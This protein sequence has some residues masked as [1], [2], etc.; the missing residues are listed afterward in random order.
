MTQIL[1]VDDDR[2]VARLV[3]RCFEGSDVEVLTSQRA[4]EVIPLIEKHTIDVLLLDI[5]LPEISGLDLARQIRKIDSK[6][7]IIFVTGR[8]DSE[9]TI[10]A[11]KLGAYDYLVK[12]LDVGM[13]QELVERAIENRRLMHEPVVLTP[14]QADDHESGDLLVGRSPQMLAV[15]KEVGRV[16]A[17]NVNVLIR[18]ESGSG[19]E[20]IARAIYQHS[21]RNNQPFLA[22]NCAALSETLLESELF[23]HEKGAFTGADSR[24]IGKFEQCNGG[25]IFLDEVGDMSLTIQAKVLRLLQDQRFERLGGTETITTDVRIISATNRDLE[26]MIADGDFRLDLFH[27]LKSFEIAIPPLR[28]RDGDLEQLVQ[29]FLKQFNRQLGKEITGLSA[30]SLARLKAYDWP[31]NIRELQGVLRKSM[32]MATSTVLAPEWLPPELFGGPTPSRS[33]ESHGSN[34]DAFD[35]FLAQLESRGSEDM[36][37]ESLE[38]MEQRLLSFVLDKTG[39]NQSK[40]AALLGITR[41]SLRH[42]MRALG[43]TVEQVVKGDD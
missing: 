4:D 8:D 5:M 24:R 29:Y 43:I 42:K 38:W 10:E 31:G 19:K 22:V 1:V 27:R 21:N 32:L 11:M 39:G 26:E 7:P 28:D 18:G 23:G 25:T 41:G 37:A 36:Y 33:S 17:Q 15:Y 40:A 14:Q 6:L 13:V 2:A 12:P 34:E 20:L 35:I 3:Q 16:A 9:T 30:E